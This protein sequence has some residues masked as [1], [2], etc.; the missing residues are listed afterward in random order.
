MLVIRRRAGESFRIGD[1]VEVEIL[2][3][4]GGQVKIGIRAP[5]E[6]PVL[7]TEMFLTG[8]QNK[9]A[10]AQA[11]AGPDLAAALVRQ[12]SSNPPNSSSNSQ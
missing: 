12:F 2:E 6:V 10:A 4:A 3:M 11:A 7:R 1:N 8:Q 9:A 5:R